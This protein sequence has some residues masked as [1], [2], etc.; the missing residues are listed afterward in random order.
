MHAGEGIVWGASLVRSFTPEGPL[1]REVSVPV[2]N[3]T[4]LAFGGA[5][6]EEIAISSFRQESS[7][8]D[9]R[10]CRQAGG[11]FRIDSG[12]RG[13]PGREFADC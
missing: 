4:C 10:Q 5:K 8:D 9:L 2:R 7:D 6:L 11:I 13:L 3:P 1:D 12:V